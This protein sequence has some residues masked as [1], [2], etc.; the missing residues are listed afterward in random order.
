M[1]FKGFSTKFQ[2]QTSFL[3]SYFFIF[4]NNVMELA[5]RINLSQ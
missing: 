5:L 3:I 4:L 1:H 2:N